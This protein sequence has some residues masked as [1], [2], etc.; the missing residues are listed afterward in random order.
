MEPIALLDA[1]YFESGAHAACV[2]AQHWEDGEAIESRSCWVREVV[3]YVP[4]RF[5]E[6][7][8]PSL[9][10]VL[11]LVRTDVRAL[12]VDSYVELDGTGTPGLGAHLYEHFG[13]R[14]AVVGI[15]KRAYRGSPFAARVMR[16]GSRRPLYVTARGIGQEEAGRLVAAMHGEH[17]IPTLVSTVDRMARQEEG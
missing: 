3:P 15:A 7:E 17:R 9:L 11:E 4:G 6:R 5:Y 12:V 1:H 2:V 10:A 14:Y 13:G 16:R 8:L